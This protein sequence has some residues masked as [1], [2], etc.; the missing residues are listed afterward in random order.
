MEEVARSLAQLSL[1]SDPKKELRHLKTALFGLG[2]PGKTV[3][4]RDIDLRALFDAFNTSDKLGDKAEDRD[5][6]IE[7]MS[8]S[9]SGAV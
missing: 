7:S 3:L 4:P 9:C 8:D 2:S 1:S 5:K 6:S